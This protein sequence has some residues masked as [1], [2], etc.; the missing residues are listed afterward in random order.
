MR[1]I[2]SIQSVFLLVVLFAVSSTIA[3]A[4]EKKVKASQIRNT[5]FISS[6][7]SYKI[8]CMGK[9]PGKTRK[10]G[11]I[12]YFTPFK[13]EE[14]S[15][16]K[17][18]TKTKAQSNRLKLLKI[19][20][21]D[22][23]KACV[24]TGGGGGGGGT[25]PPTDG[26]KPDH[27]SLE[28]YQGTF[29]FQ[30]AQIL[31]NRFAFGGTPAEIQAAVNTGL[32]AT[33]DRLFS[34]SAEAPLEAA[35][36]DI[37]CDT[38]LSNDPQAGSQN[39]QCSTTNVNDFSRSGTR[40]GLL[41]RFI[42]SKNPLFHKLA[43]FLMDER[44]AVNISAARDCEKH[45]IKTYLSTVYQAAITGDYRKYMQAMNVDQ[46]VHLRWLDGGTNRGG[47]A[48][49]PNENYA[50]EFWELGTV[51]PTDLTGKPVYS[52][53]DIANSALALTGWNV[54]NVN[55]NGNTV[56]LA[57]YVPLFHSP[58]PKT[59][60][61]GTPYQST[62]DNANDLLAATFLHPR[63]AEHLAEDIWKEFVNPFATPV[64]IRELAEVIRNSNYNL[65]PA[66]RKVMASK[67]MY[68]AQSRNSL[69]KHPLDLVVGFVKATGF[70]LYYRNYDGL[71]NRLEQQVLGTNTVF[72]W[73]ERY[74]SGQQLQIEWWNVLIDYFMNVD[75]QVVK[76][77]SGWSYYDRF[78]A[79][80]HAA[81]KRTSS[82][83][84]D[85][86]ARDLGVTI[87]AGQKAELDQMMNYYLSRYGCPEQCN[88]QGYKLVR[89]LYDTDPNS[90][91][92][93]AAWSGQRRLR[94]LIAAL[95]ELPGARTK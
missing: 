47:L 2:S 27:L 13:D 72:G 85:R 55:I 52:D 90:D 39:R 34:L 24:Y 71:M 19:L 54:N 84:I 68:A 23:A 70:P 37:E 31:F 57:S 8:V 49:S 82:D 10:S 18:R 20:I 11:K 17:L 3:S 7:K 15:L 48:L 62:I 14:A 92:S 41:Y 81:G 60:F 77:K 73:N 26:P 1:S 79:D 95:M 16:K 38:W 21:K 40:M 51:A 88:G 63:V 22:G 86:V 12:I 69:I 9:A 89:Q 61:A 28:H 59:I 50:R 29:G 42:N 91:E 5:S 94:M 4:A 58:E 93:E 78:V 46:L 67:A 33:L 64:E 56:C 53:L 74:L 25:T 87:T 35:A 76:E 30:E 43:F 66:F 44:L 65:L 6:N 75:L 80:L 83:V 45:S 36:A 32:D